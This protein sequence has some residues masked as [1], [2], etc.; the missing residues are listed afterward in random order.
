MDTFF[1]LT[2]I[3]LLGAL[4]VGC[5]AKSP[6]NDPQT[7]RTPLVNVGDFP[8]EYQEAARSVA[9]SLLEHGEIPKE[10]SADVESKDE[11]K[12]LV[13]HL[14]HESAFEPQNRHAV[15]NPGGKCR[16]VKYDV[17]RCKVTKTLFWQ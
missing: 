10:F 11:G 2:L 7:K 16:D 13:F 6:S 12:I 5:S 15:G 17:T 3:I 1:R 14:W 4:A 8:A 9:A